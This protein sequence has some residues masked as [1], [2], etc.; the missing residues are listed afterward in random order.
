MPSFIARTR[1][2]EIGGQRMISDALTI[3]EVQGAVDRV[4]DSLRSQE[5]PLDE[6]K[7]GQLRLAT[8]IERYLRVERELHQLL[9]ATLRNQLTNILDGVGTSEV[10]DWAQRVVT[11][12]DSAQLG[13]V[14][15][16]LL[17]DLRMRGTQGALI[18][19]I[20]GVLREVVDYENAA[21]AEAPR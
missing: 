13:E 15:A 14:I 1:R 7:R 5:G 18:H 11:A 9:V 2:A 16:E 3:D 6:E 17:V 20:H 4:V 21:M 19:R 12:A 8:S 10:R